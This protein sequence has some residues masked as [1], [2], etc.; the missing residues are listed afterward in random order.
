[1][2]DNEQWSIRDQFKQQ[3]KTYCALDSV[4]VSVCVCLVHQ[5][6]QNYTQTNETSVVNT[7]IEYDASIETL[8]PPQHAPITLEMQS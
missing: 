5:P 7:R 3:H 6:A 1:M 8:L 4:C 2:A